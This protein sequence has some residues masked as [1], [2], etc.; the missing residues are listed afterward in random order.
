MVEILSL[1]DL[2]GLE[3]MLTQIALFEPNTKG[4]RILIK[5]KTETFLEG[6]KNKFEK[7]QVICDETNN[8]PEVLSDGELIVDIYLIPKEKSLAKSIV[9]HTI[10][11]GKV[12]AIQEHV[13]LQYNELCF[14]CRQ[15]QRL[16]EE[17]RGK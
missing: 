10:T 16:D 8:N 7:Y 3:A 4:M 9:N 15:R 5:E 1:A 6:F 17:N 14:C 2:K 11:L 12:A 13:S